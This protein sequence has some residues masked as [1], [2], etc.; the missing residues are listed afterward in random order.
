MSGSYCPVPLSFNQACKIVLQEANIVSVC[1]L[2][3]A[4]IPDVFTYR[5]TIYENRF[6]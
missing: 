5:E 4:Y 1:I 2:T 6:H 3:K